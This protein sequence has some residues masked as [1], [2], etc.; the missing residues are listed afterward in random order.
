MKNTSHVISAKEPE[1]QFKTPGGGNRQERKAKWDGMHKTKQA[2]SCA[3]EQAL[4]WS[5]SVARLF[6]YTPTIG[7]KQRKSEVQ[8]E[9]EEV[10]T[11][12]PSTVTEEGKQGESSGSNA[13]RSSGP[14]KGQAHQRLSCTT[15]ATNTAMA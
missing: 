7:V 12:A 2:I 4:P 6:S 13:P 5:S 1:R 3:V 9:T 14:R 15:N 10:R 11:G 8:T